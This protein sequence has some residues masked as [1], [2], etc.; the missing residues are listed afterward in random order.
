MSCFGFEVL[1]E[2]QPACTSKPILM[3]L[4]MGVNL[5]ALRLGLDTSGEAW[6]NGCI[7][8]SLSGDR[9]LR[10]SESS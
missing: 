2:H 4:P 5:R 8:T 3:G 6:Q 10:R 1:G 9:L 7:S